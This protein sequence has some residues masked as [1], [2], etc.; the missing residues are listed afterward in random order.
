M[1]SIFTDSIPLGVTPPRGVQF[2]IDVNWIGI[3]NVVGPGVPGAGSTVGIRA[4]NALGGSGGVAQ[5]VPGQLPMGNGFLGQ[6]LGWWA[7]FAVAIFG[8]WWLAERGVG[9][10]S[11]FSNIKMSFLSV[12]LLSLVP[13]V[14]IPVWKVIVTSLPFPQAAK[15]FV[16]AA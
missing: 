5:S 3:A 8:L 7:V 14:G 6:P 16:Q 10:R 1:K 15:T 13:L 2:A 11:D 4:T 12:M 9:E